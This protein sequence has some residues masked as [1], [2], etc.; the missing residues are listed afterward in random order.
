M[1]VLALALALVH[2]P[3]MTIRWADL[4]TDADVRRHVG[5][6]VYVVGRVDELDAVDD[7]YCVVLV[8]AAL[9]GYRWHSIVSRER[10]RQLQPGNG[11]ILPGVLHAHEVD[12]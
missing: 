8:P 11:V 1:H 4:F 3:D 6:M 7:P 12:R 5:R 10:W 9:N 2:Q